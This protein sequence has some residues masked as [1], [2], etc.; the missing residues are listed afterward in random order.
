MTT[1]SIGEVAKRTGMTTYTLRFY[2]KEGILP[3]IRKNSSGL[4][5]FNDQDL[6]CLYV[7]ECLKSAGL[8]LKEIKIYLELMQRGDATLYDRLQI[9][10][11]QKK[12]LEEQIN[13]LKSNM[14]HLKTAKKKFIPNIMI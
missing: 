6:Y 2:E 5:R 3:S 12:R 11:N 1:Y 8:P 13:S 10:L 14:R 4:R 9:I 7:I